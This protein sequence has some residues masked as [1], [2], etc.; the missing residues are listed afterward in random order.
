MTNIRKLIFSSMMSAR[1]PAIYPQKSG[2]TE[3]PRSVVVLLFFRSVDT[4]VNQDGPPSV[5]IPFCD[6]VEVHSY[7]MAPAS[8]HGLIWIRHFP[9]SEQFHLC[10]KERMECLH[11]SFF[12]RPKCSHFSS[13]YSIK[14]CWTSDEISN[15]LAR[16]ACHQEGLMQDGFLHGVF[17]CDSESA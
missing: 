14:T 9:C 13:R 6:D 10:F 15:S 2:R 4:Y 12:K 11:S 16:H 7:M 1:I 17:K 3:I 8:R 5:M